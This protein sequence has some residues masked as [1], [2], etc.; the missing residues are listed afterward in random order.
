MSHFSGRGRFLLIGVEDGKGR[1]G[2]RADFRFVVLGNRS[3]KVSRARS[4]VIEA[5]HVSDLC[6][7]RL[8][9]QDGVTD[10][11]A[12][13]GPARMHARGAMTALR[14]MNCARTLYVAWSF[15]TLAS[16]GPSM[17]YGR[18]KS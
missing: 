11:G 5:R 2:A 7:T 3:S 4:G 13:V 6:G 1:E 10:R 12:A 15:A 18:S 16:F 14:F 9:Y 8:G 17:C